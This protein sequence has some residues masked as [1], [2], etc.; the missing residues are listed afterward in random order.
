MSVF[1]PVRLHA[2]EHELAMALPTSYNA[3]STG[4]LEVALK[5]LPGLSVPD[6]A[7]RGLDVPIRMF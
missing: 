1:E 2:V 4:V 5:L 7:P 3:R 6:M